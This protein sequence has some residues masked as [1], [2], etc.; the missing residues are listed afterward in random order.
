MTLQIILSKYN[1]EQQQQPGAAGAAGPGSTA[2]PTAAVLISFE[3]WFNH[4][5]YYRYLGV[6]VHACLYLLFTTDTKLS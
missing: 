4:C 2:A 1:Q 6:P 5:T 3:F